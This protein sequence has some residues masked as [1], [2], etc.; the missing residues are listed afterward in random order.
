M[1]RESEEKFNLSFYEVIIRPLK[2][3]IEK[4]RTVINN[5]E[6]QKMFREAFK[7]TLDYW[8]TLEPNLD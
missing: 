6:E 7:Q 2:K 5:E 4:N 8:L 1:S 3:I